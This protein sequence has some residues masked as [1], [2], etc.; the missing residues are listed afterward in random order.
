MEAMVEVTRRCNYSCLYCFREGLN[1]EYLLDM[2]PELFDELI[3]Q[4]KEAGIVKLAFT[5][6]GEPLIHPNIIGFIEKAKSEGFSV[7]VNTNGYYLL[8]YAERLS[9]S[10]V[11]EIVVSIDAGEEDPYRLIRIG[12][13]LKMVAKGLSIIKEYKKR[14][15]SL[16][17]IVKIQFTLSKIN[18]EH[19]LS[20]A[21][22]AKEYRIKDVIISNVIP[23]TPEN[24]KKLSCVNDK[25]FLNKLNMLRLELVKYTLDTNINFQLP[26]FKIKTERRCPFMEKDAIYIT[27]EGN[28]SP[29]IYYAHPWR[30]ILNGIPREIVPVRFGNIQREHILDIW[31]KEEYVRFRFNTRFSYMPSCLDCELEKVCLIARSNSYDCWGN[32]PTCSHCPYSRNIVRCPL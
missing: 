2:R 6:W 20:V 30:P 13:D 26:E 28:V 29:C 21:E 10:N 16:N 25:E 12:G 4:S 23:N 22:L 7:L 3:K 8:K 11:D 27:A 9:K 24:E 32:T 31:R 17:P 1:S 15:G 18:Y 19:I 14:N 5:G